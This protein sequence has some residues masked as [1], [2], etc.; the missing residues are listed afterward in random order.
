[1]CTLVR[2]RSTEWIMLM[3]KSNDTKR[4]YYDHERNAFVVKKIFPEINSLV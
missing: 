4:S 2:I 1:M 3:K